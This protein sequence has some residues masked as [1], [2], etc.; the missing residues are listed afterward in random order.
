[1]SGTVPLGLGIRRTIGKGPLCTAGAVTYRMR[2]GNG[3]YGSVA[4][5]LYQDKYNYPDVTGLENNCPVPYKTNF[6]TAIDYWQNIVTDDEKKEYHR[7]ASKGLRMSGY[8][9]FLREALTGVYHMYVDRGDP[10]DY[11]FDKED[12]DLDGAWH[13][14]DLSAIVPKI[15]RAVFIIGH[16]EGNGIDWTIMFRKKG[17]TNEINHGGMETIRANVERH[18][19]SIVAIGNDQIIEYKADN[20]AWATLNLGVR[21]WWT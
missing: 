8:N 5:K 16:V 6:A 7:R 1:M 9:L 13:D 17:N 11:D 20:Q 2:R 4:G 18:R 12:L 15:A 14:L 21:G 10:A 19:S 3:S